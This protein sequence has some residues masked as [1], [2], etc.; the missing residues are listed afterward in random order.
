MKTIKRRIPLPPKQKAAK[1]ECRWAWRRRDELKPDWWVA[2]HPP[3]DKGTS[4]LVLDTISKLGDE[5][6]RRGYDPLSIKFECAKEIG[7]EAPAPPLP[8]AESSHGAKDAR[9]D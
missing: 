7:A 3:A 4:N 9:P 2:W 6:V 8:T 1:I 5:L